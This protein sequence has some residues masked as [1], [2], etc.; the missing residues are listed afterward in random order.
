MAK[1]HFLCC[2]PLRLGAILISLFQSLL[3]GSAAALAWYI[4]IRSLKTHILS[5][6]A[7]QIPILTFAVLTTFIAVFC[8]IG[9]L[10]ATCK[11]LGYINFY[12]HILSVV[13]FI[14]T[15]VVVVEIVLLFVKQHDLLDSC[16]QAGNEEADCENYLT[17]S[18]WIVVVSSLVPILVEAYGLVI[19]YQYRSQLHQRDSQ[20]FR[21]AK[22]KPLVA[23]K[24][25]CSYHPVGL[26]GFDVEPFVGDYS[27]RSSLGTLSRLISESYYEKTLSQTSL[28]YPGD[29]EGLQEDEISL[30]GGNTGGLYGFG[31][32]PSCVYN[33][34]RV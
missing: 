13:F 31:G 25:S 21:E 24:G 33:V 6:D 30:K 4:L 20:G 26:E 27:V 7:T 12:A 2:L 15:A 5:P 10:G 17:E 29:I 22:L 11:R 9:F 34:G 3:N 14:K 18:K 19:I 8:F 32:G 1:H 23:G 28:P 16:V